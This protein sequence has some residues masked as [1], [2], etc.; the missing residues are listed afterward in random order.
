M[1]AERR[2]RRRKALAKRQL[3][4]WYHENRS[5]PA[6]STTRTAR[7]SRSRRST[8]QQ[9]SPCPLCDRVCGNRGALGS[10]VKSAHNMSLDEAERPG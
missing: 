9:D 3:P 4:D 8:P 2:Q 7:R 10:H 1:T 5:A 6:R